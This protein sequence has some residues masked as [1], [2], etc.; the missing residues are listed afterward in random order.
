MKDNIKG[1][2]Y[3]EVNESRKKYGTNKITNKKKNTI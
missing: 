2:T 1:L 3:K